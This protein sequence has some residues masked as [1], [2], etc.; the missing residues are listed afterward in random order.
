MTNEMTIAAVASI[1][2]ALGLYL[3]GRIWRCV[4]PGRSTPKMVE[5]RRQFHEQRERLELKLICLAAQVRSGSL[6]RTDRYD[7]DD[8]VAYAKNRYTGEITALVTVIIELASPEE[9]VD[10][11]F[12]IEQANER[13]KKARRFQVA[14]A[15]FRYD[16][17]RWEADGRIIFHL[18]PAETLR[19]YR[20]DLKMIEME[21]AIRAPVGPAGDRVE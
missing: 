14:T 20:R 12:S 17:D 10:D 5:I 2:L 9:S 8:D 7:F 1:A 15:V 11:L 18:N 19:Y 21:T 13:A 3:W 6:G 4:W 16:H